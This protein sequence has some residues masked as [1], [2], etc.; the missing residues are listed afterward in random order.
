MPKGKTEA[1]IKA[2]VRK[3]G[4]AVKVR[5]IHP[6]PKR[7]DEYAHVYVVRRK[8]PRG[9]KTIMGPIQRGK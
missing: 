4:G 3:R 9:G 8:G 6:N 7:P 1:K 2:E 5:T